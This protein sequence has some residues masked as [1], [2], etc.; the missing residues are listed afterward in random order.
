MSAR[1]AL[2]SHVAIAEHWLEHQAPN[3]GMVPDI[4]RPACMACG[5]F[6]R[7]NVSRSIHKAWSQA[8]LERCHIIPHALGGSAD[9]A[10]LVL[11][12]REC[13]VDSPDVADR[14]FMLEWIARRE[15]GTYF[16]RCHRELDRHPEYLNLLAGVHEGDINLAVDYAGSYVL[17]SSVSHSGAISPG[18]YAAS[19]IV[20]LRKAS[21]VD[22]ATVHRLVE[23]GELDRQFKA[24]LDVVLAERDAERITAAA[25]KSH[26]RSAEVGAIR[27]RPP[28]G[29][30][31]IRDRTGKI[32]ER[33][34]DQASSRNIEEIAQR[35]LSGEPLPRA[36]DD[37]NRRKIAAPGTSKAWTRMIVDRL[38]RVPHYA[39]LRVHRGEVVGVGSWQPIFTPEDRDRLISILDSLTRSGAEKYLLSGIAVCSVCGSTVVGVKSK[40]T[41]YACSSGSRCVKRSEDFANSV[42]EDAIVHRLDDAPKSYLGGLSTRAVWESGSASLLDRRAIVRDLVESITIMPVGRGRIQCKDRDAIRVVL[43]SKDVAA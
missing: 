3:S 9:P 12:C 40:Y 32:T 28:Y 37:F 16:T 13:H 35:L 24:A 43:R 8:G 29:Y 23:V 26:R 20:G 30:R 33:V 41:S 39:G 5:W 7:K 15:D 11:M 4:N 36:V 14:E 21:S 27:G 31:D 10:N 6:P 18:T 1:E 22:A 42:V 34:K 2:P 38:L 17:S 25:I 19:A